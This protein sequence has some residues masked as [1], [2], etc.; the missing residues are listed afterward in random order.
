MT[1]G[2]PGTTGAGAAGAGSAA[3]TALRAIATGTAPAAAI[4]LVANIFPVVRVRILGV[5]PVRSWR[6]R[7]EAIQL[8]VLLK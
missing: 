5:L 2:V 1:S 6:V 8:L 3:A 4:M 7:T